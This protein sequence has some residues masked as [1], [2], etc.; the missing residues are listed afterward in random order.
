MGKRG[1]KP[2][3]KVEIKWSSNFAYAI[4]LLASDGSLSKD[5]RHISFVSKDKNQIL[6]FLNCLKIK[7]KISITIS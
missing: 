5:R 4:G 7:L 3:G 6:N 2:E 1:P